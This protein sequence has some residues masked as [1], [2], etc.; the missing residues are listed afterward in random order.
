MAGY[1]CCR[2]FALLLGLDD[3]AEIL[4][5]TLDEEGAADKKLTEVAMNGINQEAAEEATAGE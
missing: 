5:T 2:S 3:V 1:G 4:Q